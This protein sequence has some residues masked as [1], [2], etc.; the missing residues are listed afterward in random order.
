M[1]EYFMYPIQHISEGAG[2]YSLS[3]G[4]LVI[5][6]KIFRSLAFVHEKIKMQGQKMIRSF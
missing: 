1:S 4:N 2:F 6:T 3:C 5:I